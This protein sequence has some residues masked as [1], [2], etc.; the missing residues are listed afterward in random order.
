MRELTV[1]ISKKVLNIAILSW[2]F[3]IY[4]C[5][6]ELPIEEPQ[7]KISQE[8]RQ[9][10][11]GIQKVLEE[12]Q[13]IEE[14]LAELQKK[15]SS[16]LETVTEKQ[17]YIKKGGRVL[18]LSLKGK[19]QEYIEKILKNKSCV[20][21][22]KHVV[23]YACY[24]VIKDKDC[25]LSMMLETIHKAMR[26][27]EYL[28][29]CI[30]LS[31][32]EAIRIR[33]GNVIQAW[34]QALNRLYTIIKPP[35]KYDY[36]NFDRS[37]Y[38]LINLLRNSE[39][40]NENFQEYF[41]H[42]EFSGNQLELMR[43]ILINKE[44]LTSE[45]RQN[46]LEIIEKYQ[47]PKSPLY[48]AL[49]IPRGRSY[50]FS[51][52]EEREQDEYSDSE[53]EDAPHFNGV[54]NLTKHGVY[55][56]YSSSEEKRFYKPILSPTG[57]PIN[58]YVTRYEEIHPK[59]LKE[60]A[61][62]ISKEF[63]N[64]TILCVA[65]RQ[66]DGRIKKFVFTN[67]PSLYQ[68]RGSDKYVNTEKNL[69]DIAKRAHE[70]CYHVIMAQQAHAEGEFMQFLQER[71]TRYTHIIAIGCS[72]PHCSYCI[73]ML[74]KFMGGDA[75]LKEITTSLHGGGGKHTYWLF[76]KALVNFCEEHMC[77]PDLSK[78]T[79]KENREKMERDNWEDEHQ[80]ERLSEEE[81]K[82]R[83]WREKKE[84]YFKRILGMELYKE[85]YKDDQLNL[86]NSEK[87]S[88][89]RYISTLA[90]DQV[91]EKEKEEKY[92]SDHKKF[93]GNQEEEVKEEKRKEQ[94]EEEEEVSHLKTA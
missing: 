27:R 35:K 51:M 73:N 56:I 7:K 89:K 67:E 86:E 88:L 53:E 1:I 25:D 23:A 8:A 48:S 44:T 63:S 24:L 84:D 62:T 74:S 65:L 4:G 37:V 10:L 6:S 91:K 71:P 28:N 49:P 22:T 69:E 26:N 81:W 42:F 2:M 33:D 59:I 64:I 13:E 40:L 92:E 93:K 83:P 19:Y 11:D 82:R 18:Y 50:K 12:K 75:K 94:E 16:E 47:K 58:N 17:E 57:K 14:T 68:F 5:Y 60:D 79:L 15:N 41:I 46:F 87:N 45:K 76:P 20:K 85:F 61:E 55:N 30:A 29:T 9:Q 43:D 3:F 34:K 77:Y 78:D 38:A 31:W 70:R 66:N 21:A 80:H 72:I 52:S 90:I 54:Y 32:I 39:L 36:Y